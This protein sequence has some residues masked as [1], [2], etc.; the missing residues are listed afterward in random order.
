MYVI[1]DSSFIVSTDGNGTLGKVL[2]K[3]EDCS[4]IDDKDLNCDTGEVIRLFHLVVLLSFHVF[5]IFFLI[6]LFL[7]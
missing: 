7:I 2:D 3:E 6:V 4:C 5:Y 1:L